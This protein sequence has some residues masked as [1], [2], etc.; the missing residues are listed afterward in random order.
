MSAFHCHPDHPAVV[1]LPAI[2][3]SFRKQRPQ[4]LL[5]RLAGKGWRVFFPQ[6]PGGF[7]LQGDEIP[8]TSVGECV[9]FFTIP[10]LSGRQFP[11]PFLA[12]EDLQKIMRVVDELRTKERIH[13]AVILCQSPVWWPVAGLLKESFG[14]PLIYDR[15]DLHEGFATSP[16]DINELENRLLA[17]AELVTFTSQ[18]LQPEAD[19]TTARVLRLPNAC[20]PHCWITADPADETDGLPRPI[21]GYFGAISDWFDVELVVRV[22]VA[23]PAWTFVLVGSTWG[24]DVTR[25]QQLSNVHLLGERPCQDLPSLGAAF[26]VGIIPFRNTP[27]TKATDPVK[28][29][30]MLAL[31][32]DVV[33]TP[34]PEL[35]KLGNELVHLAEGAE[36][37]VEEIERCLRNRPAPELVARRRAFATE[38]SWGARATELDSAI[39]NVFP[40]VSIVIVT[41]NNKA[42]TEL[43][44][45]SIDRFTAY[46]NYRVVVADNASTD[47]TREW[48]TQQARIRKNLRVILNDENLG[49]VAANNHA[50]AEATEE[51]FCL[52]NNDVVVTRGWLWE[53]VRTLMTSKRVGLVGPSTNGVA[54]EARV[55]PGY[56]DLAGLHEW[57]EDFVWRHDGR[58]FSI[59]ML[60]L[61]CTA[62]RREVWQ[63]VGGLDERFEVGMFEDDDFSRRIRRAG[64]DI[65]CLRGAWVHH[66]QEA[67]FGALSEEEYAGIYEANRRRYR[68]KWRGSD[69]TDRETPFTAVS[70]VSGESD[71]DGEKD[72]Q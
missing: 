35:S 48:L 22:A 50:F 46:P 32:L 59:P 10:D 4:H 5:S 9:S 55:E 53:M 27:L 42:L 61:Y 21:V 67:S 2:G 54:N 34:L 63:E 38:N 45:D 25:L 13:E 31:G 43:C 18:A 58:S 47:G 16:R 26:D 40:R 39:R 68:D 8:E 11:P 49:F 41:F 71:G 52:L 17:A 14:W 24:V 36:G 33:A 7:G 60:A 66:F 20:E 23:R 57:A 15:M 44:L 30:E 19:L 29:Y 72:A 69:D 70:S 28:L 62:L 12:K 56:Q 6:P 64:Y 1:C 37:F 51:I 65:R 3:W